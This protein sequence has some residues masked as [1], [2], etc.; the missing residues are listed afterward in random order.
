MSC[1]HPAVYT[2][3]LQ[4]ILYENMHSQTSDQNQKLTFMLECYLLCS[5]DAMNGL[6][7]SLDAQLSALIQHRTLCLLV[8]MSF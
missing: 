4:Y 6:S 8:T 2:R 3:V 5:L 1:S 7:V